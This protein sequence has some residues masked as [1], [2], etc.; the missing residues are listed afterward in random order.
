[1]TP[2]G[3]ESVP[4]PTSP[5]TPPPSPPVSLP[6][7]LDGTKQILFAGWAVSVISL[8]VAYKM[9]GPDMMLMSV[10]TGSITAFSAALFRDIK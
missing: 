3:K 6:R 8:L 10:F 4:D 7:T 1:M 2:V 5:T 9:F